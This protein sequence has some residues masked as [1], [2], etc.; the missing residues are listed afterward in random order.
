VP[1][2]LEIEYYRRLA[3]RALHRRITSVAAPDAWY[4]KSGLVGPVVVAELVGRSFV[5]ARRRGKLLLLDLDEGTTVGLRFGMTGVLEIDDHE[6]VDQLEYSSLRRDPAWIRFEVGFADGGA[7]RMRDPRRLGGVELDPVED[8]LGPDAISL[9]PAQLRGAL[10][11]SHAPLKARLLDQQR[12]AGLGNLLTDEILWRA[13]LAPDRE[14]GTLTAPEV[15]RLHR[16]LRAT[17]DQL[18]ER[19]GSHLG[20]LMAARE[21]GGRCPRCGT[22]LERRTIGG[23][24]TYSCP[25]EQR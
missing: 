13:R 22:E 20:T 10:D 25:R 24:T 15:R 18:L 16:Q 21:R 7:L 12:V 17:L 19:G 5:A 8:R 2:I 4:L 6:G 23:R 11:G 9:T 14:A 3:E 1:E